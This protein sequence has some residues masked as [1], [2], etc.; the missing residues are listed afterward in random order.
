MLFE[1]KD[2][3]TEWEYP[4]PSLVYLDALH[5][6]NGIINGLNRVKSTY[7]N[8]IIVMDDYGHEM[9]T[10]KPIIDNLLKNKEIKVLSWIGENKDFIAANGK[11]FVDKEGLI[12]K[13]QL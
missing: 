2:I 3:N 7:P 4:Q 12:F 5:D 6:Y 1:V 8:S 13:F 9:N 11:K 10:V